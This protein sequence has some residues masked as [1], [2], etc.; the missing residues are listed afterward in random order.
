M[1]TAPFNGTGRLR[2]DKA[3]GPASGHEL[4][5]LKAPT[6]LTVKARRSLQVQALTSIMG[7]SPMAAP[8]RFAN[9]F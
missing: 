2:G 8:T 3:K 4:K 6:S 1:E 9:F 5:R 7:A